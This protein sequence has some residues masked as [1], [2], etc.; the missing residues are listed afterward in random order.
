[1]QTVLGM[2]PEL[3]G[4][5]KIAEIFLKVA[6]EEL[7]EA[8][9]AKSTFALA[10]AIGKIATEHGDSKIRWQ[11]NH[12]LAEAALK[13]GNNDLSAWVLA[14]QFDRSLHD[15]DPIV[16]GN[17]SYYVGALAEKNPPLMDDAKNKLTQIS[18]EST[19][20]RVLHNARAWLKEFSR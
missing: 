2:K 5:Y 4:D 10:E 20:P 19:D 1:M 3:Q 6:G 11:A 7:T 14:N 18:A 15:N 9:D 17:A 12:E 13:T 16:R 8:K